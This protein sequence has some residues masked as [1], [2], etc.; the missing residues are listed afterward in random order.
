MGVYGRPGASLRSW[1]AFFP[2]A[3]IYGADIDR[4]ILFREDRIKTFYCDQCD[5]SS[6]RSMW[7]EPELRGCGLD[8]IIEDGLHTFESNISFLNAS[9]EHL[10]VGGFYVTEDISHSAFD[11]WIDVLETIYAKRFAAY[12]IG[13]VALPN[14]LNPYND[15]NLLIIH[16]RC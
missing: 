11:K 8:V 10:R 12:E 13:L 5:D 2:R 6:I 9:L 4:D 3:L 15:N 7:S 14:P 16:R 1:R